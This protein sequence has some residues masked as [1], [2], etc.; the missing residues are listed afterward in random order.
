MALPTLKPYF[1]TKGGGGGT[2]ARI[3]K[4]A[5]HTMAEDTR[6]RMWSENNRYFKAS[7]ISSQK[8]EEWSSEKSLRKR[9][10]RVN[11]KHVT[12]VSRIQTTPALLACT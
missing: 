5:E 8:Q 4:I 3:Q 9:L 2:T 6:R 12:L 10:K 7:R 1:S 11:K